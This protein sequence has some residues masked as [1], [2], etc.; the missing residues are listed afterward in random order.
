MG[1]FIYRNYTRLCRSLTDFL[2]TLVLAVNKVIS[3]PDSEIG[4][5]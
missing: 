4:V 2:E 5:D 1:Q 3:D